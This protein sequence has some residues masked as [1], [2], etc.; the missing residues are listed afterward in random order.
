MMFFLNLPP[1]LP[2]RHPLFTIA[3]LLVPNVFFLLSCYR[4]CKKTNQPALP[5]LMGIFAMPCLGIP[6]LL[7]PPNQPTS[8]K[9]AFLRLSL[10]ALVLQLIFLFSAW[11]FDKA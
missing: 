9:G 6:Y 11:V 2:M 7:A 5:W 3:I 1:L 8:P 10:T 4:Y